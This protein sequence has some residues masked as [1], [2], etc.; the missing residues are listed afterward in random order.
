[1]AQTRSI[2]SSIEKFDAL[3]TD[4][5]GMVTFAGVEVLADDQGKPSGFAGMLVPYYVLSDRGIFFVPG[6]GKKTAREQQKQAP[7]L[8]QH[9]SYEPIGRHIAAD[10]TDKGFRIEV[11]INKETHRGAEVMS[12]LAFG[13]PMGLS[14]GMLRLSDR[15]GTDADDKLL[16]R[17]SAPD[18][19]KNVPINE[20]RAVTQWRWWEGSTVTFA[21]IGTAKPSEVR[22]SANLDDFDIASITTALKAGELSDEQL[23]QLEELA[24]AYQAFAADPTSTSTGAD[25]EAQRNRRIAV[26]QAFERRAALITQGA[27]A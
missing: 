18:Y 12:N 7:H 1:M 19:W 3:T 4:T 15:S 24:A 22:L 20:L 10:D 2:P 21:A 5:E 13:V 6:S 9:D 17:K 11:A 8:Y 23:E 25:E 27:I 14:V 16:D 26:A